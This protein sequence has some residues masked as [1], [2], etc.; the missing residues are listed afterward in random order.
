M[1]F[2][3]SLAR[4]VVTRFSTVLYRLAQLLTLAQFYEPV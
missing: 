3:V 4:A 1:L 2:S